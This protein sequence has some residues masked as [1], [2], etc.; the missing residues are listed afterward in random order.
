MSI[1]PLDWKTQKITLDEKFIH[2]VSR[3]LNSL[4]IERDLKYDFELLFQKT[5]ISLLENT[6]VLSEKV[7]AEGYDQI[8]VEV[9]GYENGKIPVS[10]KAA[11]FGSILNSEFYIDGISKNEIAVVEKLYGFS[12]KHILRLPDEK[13]IKKLRKIFNDIFVKL[14]AR[15]QKVIVRRSKLSEA[16]RAYRKFCIRIEGASVNDETFNSQ[17]REQFIDCVNALVQRAVIKTVSIQL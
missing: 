11:V 6:E 14:N 15:G 4:M 7:N 16:M 5:T 3:P 2:T 9:S 17:N 12:I 10:H 13:E 1:Y 8:K